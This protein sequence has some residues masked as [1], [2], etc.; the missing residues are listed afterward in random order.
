VLAGARGGK[1]NRPRLHGFLD[2]IAHLRD[3]IVGR[4][5]FGGPSR[6][7]QVRTEE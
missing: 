4:S 3:F 2:D 6:M 1:S 5:A 7:T